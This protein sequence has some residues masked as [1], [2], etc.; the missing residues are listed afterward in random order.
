MRPGERKK[1]VAEANRLIAAQLWRH[2]E[3]G[4]D[5]LFAEKD[6]SDCPSD[7]IELRFRVLR[8]AVELFQ[9]RGD[10]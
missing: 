3:D 2:F 6:G 9:K 1:R 7:V 4:S 8:E 10:R 5:F